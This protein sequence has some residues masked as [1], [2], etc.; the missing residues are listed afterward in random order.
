MCIVCKDKLLSGS[1]SDNW[2]SAEIEW[3]YLGEERK[4]SKC[5]CGQHIEIEYKLINH[6]TNTTFILG[7][8]C[9]NNVFDKIKSKKLLSKVNNIYCNHCNNLYKKQ[10]FKK[11]L[12]SQKHIDNFNLKTNWKMCED[13]CEYNLPIDDWKTKCRPCYSKSKGYRKCRR[14][15]KFNIKLDVPYRY[16]FKC[17]KGSLY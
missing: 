15:H 4:T 11:H 1:A 10:T 16:C 17:Y 2:D 13:C 5:I 8:V 6:A 12:E 7:S 3:Q 9:I 14:C